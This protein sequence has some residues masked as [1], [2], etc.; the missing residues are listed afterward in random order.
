MR[1]GR[2]R[3]IHRHGP[4]IRSPAEISILRRVLER[5]GHLW[6]LVKHLLVWR[7]LRKLAPL[8]LAW[9]WYLR[10][11]HRGRYT[12]LRSARKVHIAVW[13]G[14]AVVYNVWHGYTL[15]RRLRRA[16]VHSAG[17]VWLSLM[18]H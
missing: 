18:P 1:K 13:I 9:E 15:R 17:S 3:C 7:S 12:L 8:W 2:Q 14:I 11:V 16:L 6:W 4:I 5:L 10:R